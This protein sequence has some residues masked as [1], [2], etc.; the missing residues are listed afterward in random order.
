[1]DLRN[2]LG[3]GAASARPGISFTKELTVR[4]LQ[5]LALALSS[6]WQA[7]EDSAWIHRSISELDRISAGQQAI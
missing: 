2:F 1:V 4:L 7:D 3:H 5:L 6:F